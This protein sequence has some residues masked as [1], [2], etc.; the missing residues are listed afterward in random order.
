MR[1]GSI[2]FGKTEAK[3]FSREDWT[4]ESALNSLMNF[5]FSRI[6]FLGADEGAIADDSE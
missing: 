2:N 1:E 5:D 6:R 3:Y 4:V